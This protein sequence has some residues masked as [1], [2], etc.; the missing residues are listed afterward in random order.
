[1]LKLLSVVEGVTPY[2]QNTAWIYRTDP[3]SGQRKEIPIDLKKL[4]A[5]KAPDVDLQADDI[6]YIPDA[7]NKRAALETAKLL[8]TTGSGAISAVIYAGI[9]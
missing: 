3:A 5:R 4:L 8:L 6:L 9:H 1:V 2:A 7:A